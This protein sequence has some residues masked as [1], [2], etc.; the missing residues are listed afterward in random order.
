MSKTVAS[1]LTKTNAEG[2]EKDREYIHAQRSIP[3]N[4]FIVYFTI[5]PAQSVSNILQKF[6][7]VCLNIVSVSHPWH[8]NVAPQTAH[9]PR[10][11]PPE[12]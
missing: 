1:E 6:L 11:P 4:M 5:C 9:S 8:R 2:I 3:L 7:F 10:P 12:L